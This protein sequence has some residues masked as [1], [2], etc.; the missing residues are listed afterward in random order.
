MNGNEPARVLILAAEGYEEAELLGP[1]RALM[2]AGLEVVLASI[3][4]RPIRGVVYDEATGTSKPSKKLITPDLT[5]REAAALRFDAL[6]L[7]GGLVNPDRLRIESDAVAIVRRYMAA[8][9]PV[10]AIC[11]APWLLVEADVLRGR[12]ATGWF[13]I[14]TDLANAGA[15]VVDA[16][17][18]V[19]GNLITSRMPSDIPDFTD[20]LMEKIDARIPAPKV[21]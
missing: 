18:V 4:K 1:R 16:A 17:V 6:L 9:V 13:S 3:D 5:L 14:H 20:A 7:P 10:A 12:R 11:H 19:D 8:G 15:R 21:H 2:A